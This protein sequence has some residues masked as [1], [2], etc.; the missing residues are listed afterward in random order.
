MTMATDD[1][2]VVFETV[3]QRFNDATAA[4]EELHGTLR[5][6]QQADETQKE[7]ATAL[8]GASERLQELIDAT[9][10]SCELLQ[11]ALEATREAL[12][13]A[14]NLA[15]G[16]ELT[17]IRTGVEAVE[18]QVAGMLADDATLATTGT[19]VEKIRGRIEQ[20]LA[21]DATLATTGSQVNYIHKWLR[22]FVADN[23]SLATL[24]STLTEIHDLISDRLERSE[25]NLNAT[26]AALAE[27]KERLT[28]IE[29][30]LATVPEKTRRKFNL[31]F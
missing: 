15:T 10:A 29:S 20:M 16:T 23:G 28:M 19:R 3:K 26:N 18:A 4:L 17:A 31:V 21:D 22:F 14:E 30:R 12:A 11:S 25:Q 9:K 8:T 24:D 27:A 7:A 5:S 6:L 1:V 2:P 13:S